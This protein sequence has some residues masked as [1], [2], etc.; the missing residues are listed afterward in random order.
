MSC[1]LEH[2]D[3]DPAGGADHDDTVTLGDAGARA[4]MNGGCYC[5]RYDRRF[6]R[7]E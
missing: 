1:Y 7:V 2:V 6:D 5:I 4:D 3:T